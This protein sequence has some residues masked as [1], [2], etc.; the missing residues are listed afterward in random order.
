MLVV[1]GVTFDSFALARADFCSPVTVTPQGRPSA[2]KPIVWG[3]CIWVLS[4][5][6]HS[7][8]REPPRALIPGAIIPPRVT[9]RGDSSYPCRP[10]RPWVR[11]MPSRIRRLV[12]AIITPAKHGRVHARG[13]RVR[14]ERALMATDY[15][16]LSLGRGKKPAGSSVGATSPAA[17]PSSNRLPVSSSVLSPT[18]P[19]APSFFCSRSVFLPHPLSSERSVLQAWRVVFFV[20]RVIVG[21]SGGGVGVGV[22]CAIPIL[23]GSKVCFDTA[24]TTPAFVGSPS[25]YEESS[26]SN[27]GVARDPIRARPGWG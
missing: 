23:S 8:R 14:T 13:V 9:A 12:A 7:I 27:R 24:W 26:V 4:D 16:P 3:I 1:T 5:G 18:M 22:R 25:Q 21:S 2:G 11:S 6:P 15:D 17:P 20:V 10:R 19:L